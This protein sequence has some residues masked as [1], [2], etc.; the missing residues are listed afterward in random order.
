[1]LGQ[2]TG[3]RVVPAGIVRINLG[4]AAMASMLAEGLPRDL[5]EI[6]SLIDDWGSDF[7]R[8]VPLW[9]ETEI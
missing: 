7:R 5:P 4:Q 3:T 6:A 1:V 8:F 2:W 9:H